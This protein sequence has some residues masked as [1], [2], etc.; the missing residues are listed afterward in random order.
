MFQSK[1][2][3][4]YIQMKEENI[5]PLLYQSEYYFNGFF[6]VSYCRYIFALKPFK[7]GHIHFQ[8]RELWQSFEFLISR[9][10]TSYI[11]MLYA[12]IVN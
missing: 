8:R 2:V 1:F 12:N 6:S 5:L 3:I 4:F 9:L 11:F 10:G 7:L